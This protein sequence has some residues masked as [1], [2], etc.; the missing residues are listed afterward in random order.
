[1]AGGIID[2]T[3][4]E[5]G[6][7]FQR[8]DG[9]SVFLLSTPET[10]RL[11]EQFSSFRSQG[12]LAQ[13]ASSPDSASDAAPMMSVAP[14]AAPPPPA[15]SA[16]PPPAPEPVNAG[17]AGPLANVATAEA[18]P[19]M[20]P[21]SPTGPYDPAAAAQMARMYATR[22]GSPG[23]TKEQ[24]E[25]KA[26]QAVEMP[27]SSQ[28]TVEGALPYDEELAAQRA[29]AT[30][31]RREARLEQS[32]DER[33]AAMLEG[34]AQQ[35][36]AQQLQ[37]QV[38]PARQALQKIEAGVENDRKRYQSLRNEVANGKIQPYY[39]GVG[40]AFAAV[41]AAIA[42]AM[43]AYGAGLT[44]TRNFAQD[45]IN[46]AMERD[47]QI[48]MDEFDRK[49]QA[50]DNM[51]RDLLNAYGD[52]DQAKAAL[53]GLQREA[54]KAQ[55][56]YVA[57][58]TKDA[59]AQNV[60]QEW[61]ANDLEREAETERKIRELSYGKHTQS[62]AAEM[63]YPRAATAAY[64]DPKAAGDFFLRAMEAQGKQAQTQMDLAK[65]EADIAKTR[66]DA[67]KAQAEAT[68]G[69]PEERKDYAKAVQAVDSAKGELKRIVEEYGYQVDDATGKVT[70]KD[71]AS[72][73]PLDLP[74]P[75]MGLIGDT[76]PI[77]KLQN[78]L[79]S[80]GVSFGRVVNEGGEPSADLARRLIPQYGPTYAPEDLR[81]QFESKMQS[82]IEKEKSVKAGSTSAARG[83]REQ[84]KRNA[85][86]EKA[87][88]AVTAGQEG[89][90][91]PAPQKF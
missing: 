3:P 35:R 85:N 68:G 22:P 28:V 83:A 73:F 74:D 49:G 12:M 7:D 13:N 57:S 26:R 64:V 86:I 27:K 84:E 44:G 29:Q 70:L 41:G 10:D 23:V 75:T 5:G 56:A 87:R 33:Y 76:T 59:T 20:A 61:M 88:A 63:A 1:M 21:P 72:G 2:V 71:G 51:Y 43:G 48:Q 14:P 16:M 17:T 67:A 80:F 34:E 91:L 30:D 60:L 55:A 42:S 8:D 37:Q 54:A 62:I 38:S 24:L 90:G 15:M 45:I 66:A 53:E 69:S 39:R 58:R 36:L 18:A 9:S 78:D 25:E 82:L 89:G 65:G 40:G 52:R 77:T 81:A 50:A 46:A 6:Y 79:T 32:V 47:V 11:A 19:P 31:M 4:S